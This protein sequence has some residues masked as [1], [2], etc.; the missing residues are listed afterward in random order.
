MS[1]HKVTT[2][3]TKMARVYIEELKLQDSVE[4]LSHVVAF[5]R[6]FFESKSVKGWEGAKL[7][8][9]LATQRLESLAEEIMDVA[10]RASISSDPKAWQNGIDAIA[11]LFRERDEKIAQLEKVR[12]SLKEHIAA[13]TISCDDCNDAILASYGQGKPR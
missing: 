5:V 6:E 4:N 13:G 8:E 7:T 1:D 2:D 3:D 9:P 12:E 11:T 10:A